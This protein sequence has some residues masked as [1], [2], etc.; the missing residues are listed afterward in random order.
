MSCALECVTLS[1]CHID[2]RN[3]KVIRLDNGDPKYMGGFS[4]E[5]ISIIKNTS[6]AKLLNNV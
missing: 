2:K 5:C 1:Q 3:K 6:V 4:S